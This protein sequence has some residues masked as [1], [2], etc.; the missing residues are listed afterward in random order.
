MA[1]P[2]VEPASVEFKHVPLGR[3]TF[4]RVTL[5]KAPSAA[6]LTAKVVADGNGVAGPVRVKTVTAFRMMEVPIN[7]WPGELPPGVQPPRNRVELAN[8]IVGQS[9][10][11]TPL[12]LEKNDTVMIDIAAEP[13]AASP[14]QLGATLLVS[15]DTWDPVSVPV[16]VSVSDVDSRVQS[17]PLVVQQGQ[18]GTATVTARW[19]AGPDADIK[20]E[21]VG[22][23]SAYKVSID[24]AAVTVRRGE[25]KTVPLTVRV[26]PDAPPGTKALRI[27]QVGGGTRELTFSL[28]LTITPAPPP[29]PANPGPAA[30]AQ[31]TAKID[32]FYQQHGGFRGPFGFPMGGVSFPGGVPTRHF[33]GGTIKIL[34]NTPKGVEMRYVRVRFL[35]FHCDAESDNDQLSGS[36][37]PYF[38][39]GVAGS[40]GSSTVRFGPYSGVDSGTVR[41]EAAEVASAAH[42]I[43]PPIVL[44]VVA[45]EHDEG[46]P[47]E[48]EAKVR[49]VVQEIERKFDEAVGAF[50]GA[51]TGSHV[52]PEWTRD[53]L[54]G[55][56][57]EGIAAVFGLGDD[58]VG[59][60]PMVLFDNKVD[61]DQ[62]KA[63][64]VLGKHGPNEYN[65]VLTVDGGDE[66]KYTCYF[67]VDL[68][69]R[70]DTIE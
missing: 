66:G 54:I 67:K 5:G 20:Y 64:P 46:T 37:E 55:W 4:R 1:S 39:I 40:N 8:V 16:A 26:A 56:L 21:L 12:E 69:K 48:A 31:A 49:A 70:N 63:P 24:P 9:D 27:L 60:T 7:V 47:E 6:R 15:G 19:A 28:G 2:T 68:F 13:P 58:E 57:P 38:L 11:S 30:V 61:L 41:F 3:E 52:M 36:D 53:I 35:G 29:D 25:T 17:A 23:V 32:A 14:D 43:T 51:A 50:T 45:M 62:W 18:S 22:D 10:G 59:K 65:V 42:A 44:G 33:A 34:G